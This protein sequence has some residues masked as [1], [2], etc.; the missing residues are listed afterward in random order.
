LGE[1][2]RL[3]LI[4]VDPRGG[5]LALLL[6]RRCVVGPLEVVELRVARA[7][8]TEVVAATADGLGW[9]LDRAGIDEGI[10]LA[11]AGERLRRLLLLPARD[12]GAGLGLSLVAA[13][14]VAAIFIAA[15]SPDARVPTEVTLLPTTGLTAVRLASTAR[16]TS[17]IRLASAT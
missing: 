6:R 15:I 9:P 1:A 11:L 3:R 12:V 2:I 17:T 8:W 13:I 4:L 7:R 14:F 5:R 10:T 16:V